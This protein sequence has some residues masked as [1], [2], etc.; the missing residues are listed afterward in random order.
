MVTCVDLT[1]AFKGEG[2]AKKGTAHTLIN[3]NEK[4]GRIMD[5]SNPIEY[6][7]AFR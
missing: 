7:L 1:L 2:D 4:A 5:Y 3:A 6:S